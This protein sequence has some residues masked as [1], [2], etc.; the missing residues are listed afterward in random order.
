VL[1]LDVSSLEARL[2]KLARAIGP[3]PT[4]H[5]VVIAWKDENV[6]GHPFAAVL[7]ENAV[8]V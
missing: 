2:Q 7:V 5:T 6:L 3:I 1:G 4:P 8:R